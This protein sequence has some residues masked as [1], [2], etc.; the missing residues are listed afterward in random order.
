MSP[1]RGQ[2]LA[3]RLALILALATI[4]VLA[5]AGLVVN[6]VV[7]RSFEEQVS[8]Q[9]QQRLSDAAALIGELRGNGARSALTR[10][11]AAS[12][13][14]VTLLDAAGAVIAQAGRLPRGAATERLQQPLPDGGPG[15]TLALELPARGQ[16]RAFLRA[17]NLALLLTGVISLL[18]L[19]L[20][21]G[22]LSGRLTG[23]LRDVA[24]AAR[25]LGSGDLRA[26]AS[27]GG[28]QESQ[29]LAVAFN[30]MAD[31]LERSEVL[32]R[33]AASDMA[34]DLATPATVLESQLQ[35]MTDGVVP[36]DPPQL[37]AAR[38][39]ASAL[40]G[41]IRQLGDLIEAESS[42]LQRRPERIL[43]GVLVGEAQQ[44]L[45]HLF[46]DG[47]VVLHPQVPPDLA[48]E[49]DPAHLARAVR[50]V[51]AN[52]VQHT[53]SGG[54]VRLTAESS[55]GEVQL[56]ITDSGPGI[57]TQDL[58]HVF[59]RFYRADPSRAGGR[60]GSGIGLTIARE[61]LAANGGRIEVEQTGSEGTT[62][63]ISLPSAQAGK[64]RVEP[65]RE[66]R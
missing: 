20:V 19:M 5:V 12:G 9:Q 42:V 18:V 17:F 66:E 56:R 45:D 21:A 3:I 39:S 54:A 61:L 55:A 37:E 16:D 41:V 57:S 24:A 10:L 49:A 2:P 14:R 28:D 51:L 6:Q 25:R 27:G 22:L 26:R 60:A 8:T 13:G 30:S 7:S 50:N 47:G 1:L 29:E 15:A 65:Y 44:A 4:A 40:S 23:P 43:L 59:E 63:V 46:R 48:V 31:R 58:P 53:S 34:H 64:W 11:A 38:A 62:F 36:A 52:A 35:A 32:R 33:R